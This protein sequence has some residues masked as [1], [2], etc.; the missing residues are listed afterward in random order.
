MEENLEEEGVA[1]CVRR[2]I[3]G[4]HDKYTDQTVGLMSVGGIHARGVWWESTPAE[5]TS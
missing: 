5:P 1:G 4:G 3:R 2:G